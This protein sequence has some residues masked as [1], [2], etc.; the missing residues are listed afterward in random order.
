MVNS[1]K[2]EE[3]WRRVM[4]RTQAHFHICDTQL[5]V[6]MKAAGLEKVRSGFWEEKLSWTEYYV[7]LMRLCNLAKQ[8][9]SMSVLVRRWEVL[10]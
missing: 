8:F 4:D 3:S 9:A 1:E 10:K 6:F 2:L 5:M 7:K